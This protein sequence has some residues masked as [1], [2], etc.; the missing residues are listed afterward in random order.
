MNHVFF[1]LKFH[2]LKTCGN[3]A[4]ELLGIMQDFY[5]LSLSLSRA[6][7]NNFV[8]DSC[9]FS[10]PTERCFSFKQMVKIHSDELGGGESPLM[11]S[12]VDRFWGLGLVPL[13]LGH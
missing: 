9:V 8:K 3:N 5:F 6:M 10:Q 11:M 13:E 4:G 12:K 7:L 2:I 1:H